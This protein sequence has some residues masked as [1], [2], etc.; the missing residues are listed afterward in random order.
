M[1]TLYGKKEKNKRKKNTSKL[2]KKKRKILLRE[3]KWD[4]FQGQFESFCWKCL[5]S[6]RVNDTS[7][8]LEN[9]QKSHLTFFIHNGLW[10]SFENGTGYLYKYKRMK[11]KMSFIMSIIWNTIN[12]DRPL[13]NKFD[14][15]MI[16]RFWQE[17]KC[18]ISRYC[19]QI[20]STV[21][22]KTDSDYQF[23]TGRFS[24]LHHSPS[25]ISVGLFL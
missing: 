18:Y 7:D 5:L 1:L 20:N 9:V 10:L 15:K 11:T 13:L 12:N 4:V 19:Q 23:V 17:I 16:Q 25:A 22:L 8:I 2:R 24:E 3:Q 6:R 21:G 14:Y